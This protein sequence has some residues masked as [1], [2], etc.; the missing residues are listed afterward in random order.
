MTTHQ[1]EQQ[2]ALRILRRAVSDIQYIE[3]AEWYAEV[4][5]GEPIE[6]AVRALQLAIEDLAIALDLD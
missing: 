2:K 3:D 1:R 5:E 4:F 6:M